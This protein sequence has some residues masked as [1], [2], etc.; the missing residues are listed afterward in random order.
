MAGIAAVI[1]QINQQKE[2]AEEENHRYKQLLSI[3]DALIDKQRAALAEI[4]KTSQ[5]LQA[6][7]EKRNQLKNQLSSQKSKL[8]IAASESS[9][10]QTL[11]EQTVGADNSSPMTTSP[12]ALKCVE[13]IQKAVFSLTEAALKEDNLSIPAENMS[14]VILTVS[15]IIQNA[16]SSGA[17]KETTEDTVRRQSFVIS[18]LVPPPPESE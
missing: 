7:E 12:V 10:L 18:S 11:I 17:A 13:D 9:D 8:L 16:I 15:E 4:A 3:Q 14:D 2:I 5:E 1:S 6:V